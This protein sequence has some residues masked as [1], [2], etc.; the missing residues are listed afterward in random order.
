MGLI[1]LGVFPFAPT[2]Q[3]RISTTGGIAG[4]PLLG[5]LFGI[6]GT[7]CIGPALATVQTLAF[8][9]ASA[10]RGAILSIG[11]SIGLGIPFIL[12][13]LYLDRSKRIRTFIVQRGILVSRIGGA[14]LIAIGI[15]QLSGLWSDLMINL[16]SLI[17]DFVP[18]I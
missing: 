15:L 18:V 7:P 2:L 17:S 5:V 1:F 8:T 11:Y 9:E 10:L 4:A 16:R 3:P 14:L 6:G 13:G 12:S